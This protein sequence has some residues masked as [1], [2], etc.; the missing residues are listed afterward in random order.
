[1]KKVARVSATHAIYVYDV[2]AVE[3]DE[4]W[5]WK[6]D[7]KKNHTSCDHRMGGKI[8]FCKRDGGKIKIKEV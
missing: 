5:E 6:C 3:D 8:D 1:M 4:K 2:S 7:G